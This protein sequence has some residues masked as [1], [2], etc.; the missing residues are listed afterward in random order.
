MPFGLRHEFLVAHLQHAVGC[1]E[2][3]RRAHGLGPFEGAALVAAMFPAGVD[4]GAR[5]VSPVAQEMD[6]FGLGVEGGEGG[7]AA[8]IDRRLVAQAGLGGGAA[9]ARIDEIDDV[10]Q[11]GRAERRDV[12]QDVA[13]LD[14]E[15]G[16]AVM[17]D[18]DLPRAGALRRVERAM[19]RQF[20]QKVGDEP[21]LRRHV[22]PAMPA[23]D[24]PEQR[25]PRPPRPDNE[26]TCVGSRNG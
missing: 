19:H 5:H 21:G 9:D 17:P 10:A 13:G 7:Q 25:R 8:H 1:G 22:Q 12:G 16:P 24:Q 23:Q 3:A 4:I 2:G 11:F 20:L 18:H 14:A 6:E 26:K 15:I